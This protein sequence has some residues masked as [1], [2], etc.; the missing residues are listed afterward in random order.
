MA[1]AIPVPASLAGQ[2][3]GRDPVLERIQ[4]HGDSRVDCG[5]KAVP[6]AITSGLA[7]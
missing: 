5:W 4:A 2:P 7:Q 1:Q 3:A 6:F